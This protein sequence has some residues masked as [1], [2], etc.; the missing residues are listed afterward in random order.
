MGRAPAGYS[1][2]RI[3]NNGNYGPN[4]CRWTD[5][6]TQ[7]RNKRTNKYYTAFGKTQIM[8]DWANE[9]NINRLTFYRRLKSGMSIEEVIKK[10]S[11]KKRSKGD[12]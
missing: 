12:I 6:K 5:N 2:D 1:L 4:N 7:N 3:D 8:V 10:I 11:K 9:F